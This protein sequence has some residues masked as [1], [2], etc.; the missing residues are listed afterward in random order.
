MIRIPV[1][2]AIVLIAPS[3]AHATR[4]YGFGQEPCAMFNSLYGKQ[5][6]LTAT[7]YYSWYQGFLSS[8]N[9]AR[10]A[11][12]KPPV[13]YAT[14]DA[15]TQDDEALLHDYCV[16]HPDKLFIEAVLQLIRNHQDADQQGREVLPPTAPPAR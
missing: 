6:D 3:A 12:G 15:V 8:M 11:T 1:M 16:L 5:P 10:H 7:T 14:S 9:V 4:L 2:L 13:D